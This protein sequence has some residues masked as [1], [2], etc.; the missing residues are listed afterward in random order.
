MHLRVPICRGCLV[1]PALLLGGCTFPSSSTTLP[2]SQANILLT[3]DVGTVVGVREMVIDGR[4]SWIGR[5]GG[6]MI[7]TAAALPTNGSYSR[8]RLMGIAGASV[9]GAVVGEAVE[10]YVTRKR[11]QE[12]TVELKDGSR[13]IVVQEAPPEFVIG[14]IVKVTHGSQGAYVTYSDEI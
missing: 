12:V 6:G 10:E 11:A 8:G 14:D 5:S 1:I 9:V 4:R 13:V 3:G 2:P 7:G